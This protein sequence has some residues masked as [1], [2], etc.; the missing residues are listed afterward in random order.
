MHPR[1]TLSAI[2]LAVLSTI[3]AA[4]AEDSYTLDDVIV[5]ATRTPVTAAQT[6]SDVTVI[7]QEQI[8]N[9][10]Q[11]TLVEL[12]QAQPGLE[13]AQAGGAGTSASI[14]IRG[15]NAAHTLVLVDGVRV[16]SITLGTTPLENIAL[17]QIDHIEIVR[18][19]A[20][21]LYGSDAV[22]GVIQIFTKQGKGAPKLNAAIGLGSYGRN[23]ARVG[24]NG[25]VGDT[26]FS[27]GAGYDKTNGGISATRPGT[28]GYNPDNDG[29]TKYSA[30]LN[31]DQKINAQN[32][33][34][35]I[36]LYNRDRVE[37]DG[38]A[39]TYSDSVNQVNSISAYWKSQ[40]NSFWQSRVLIGRGENLSTAFTNNNATSHFNS[41]Q[42]QYQWQNNFALPVGTLTA[43]AERNEQQVNSSQTYTTYSRNVDALQLAYQANIGA[44]SVQASLR[45]DSYS[46]LGEHN[47][48]SVGYGYA[49]TPNWRA[50]ANYGTAFHAPS[51]NDMYYPNIGFY[52]GNPNLRPEQ[53][54]QADIGLRYTAGVNQAGVTV[55][56]NRVKNLIIYDSSVFP[57]TMSNIANA[58]IRG[59][60]LS[61]GTELAGVLVKTNYTY[62]SPE[63]DATGNLLARRAR[64][65]GTVDLAKSLGD[66]V[67]GAQA[68]ASSA[69]YNDA[70]NTTRL[71]GYTIVN[72]RASYKVNAEWRAIAKLN[73][74]FNKDYQTVSGYN[75]PG[76]N[77]FV[78]L[79]WQQK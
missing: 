28:Y 9:A 7:S 6:T 67:F 33:V 12:L 45:H 11:S 37:Y 54:R 29:D 1:Y 34:G 30:H 21:S 74:A 10:G 44:N 22:G 56:E 52:T 61:A 35:L 78:G 68:V 19:A 43:V 60:E 17:D 57:T 72:L 3:S 62:Q 70:A 66:W 15:A 49:F 55:F 26:R 32:N 39:T 41:T 36:T 76:A 25:Q 65:H 75:T 40:F 23:Q 48:G 58:T 69:R 46:D 13:L 71:G 18:G 64:Q 8:R 77:I 4:H 20:S 73:N 50:T 2:A 42:T 51:F 31:V 14:Y 16:G 27:M 63:D 47:T 79:E 5:T 59:V 24:Y 38:N 53:S